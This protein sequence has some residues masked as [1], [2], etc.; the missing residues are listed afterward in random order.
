MDTYDVIGHNQPRLNK[1]QAANPPQVRDE[2]IETKNGFTMPSST[3]TQ[4][5]TRKPRKGHHLTRVHM[6]RPSLKRRIPC[7]AMFEGGEGD[8][9]NLRN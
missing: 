3:F 4:L 5:S 9:S 8:H 6:T 1:S 7:T 2:A